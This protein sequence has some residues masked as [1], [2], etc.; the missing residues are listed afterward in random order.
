MYAI[1]SYYELR[2]PLTIVSGYCSLLAETDQSR[3]T[4]DQRNYIEE[5]AAATDRMSDLINNLLDL[6]RLQSGKIALDVQPRDLVVTVKEFLRDF[7]SLLQSNQLRLQTRL[8]Q[9]CMALF[10]DDRI[11]P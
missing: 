7:E 8:P 3:L 9:T 4:E 2:T 1:R 10:D 11:Y 6:S 5:T